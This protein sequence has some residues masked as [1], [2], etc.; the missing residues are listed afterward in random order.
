MRLAAALLALALLPACSVAVHTG[1]GGY[2]PSTI[3]GSWKGRGVQSDDPGGGWTIA[4]TLA[5]EGRG[6]VVGTITYPSLACGGDLIL[7]EA[8]AE[9][10]EVAERIT[11]GTCVDH[12]I[13]VLTPDGGGLRFDWRVEDSSLTARGTL[14]RARPPAP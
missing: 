6:S 3:A 5:G 4:L 10:V 9:R 14:S 2:V 11:F 8:G 1:H 13:I 7:R 12:G